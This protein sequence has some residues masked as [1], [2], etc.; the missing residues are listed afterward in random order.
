MSMRKSLFIILLLFIQLSC[1]DEKQQAEK[2]LKHYIDVKVDLI[3]NYTME[4]SVALWNATV[5]GSETDYQKF[6]D[7][8]LD[9]NKSN[10]KTPDYFSPDRFSSFS[11]NVFTNE[12]DFQLLRKLKFSG[13]ITDT[14]LNRQLNVL[15]HTF[16]GSQI[17]TEKYKNLVMSEMNLW[18]EFSELKVMIRG[19]KYGTRQ[20]D[21]IRKKTN[22]APL[23]NDIS[24]AIKQKGQSI[25]PDIVRMVKDRNGFATHF[26]YPDFY[27]MSLETKDQTPKNIKLLL[28]EI[29]LKTR[30]EYFEA[31]S[32]IDKLLAKRFN[33][34]FSDLQPWNYNNELSSFLPQKFISKMD[35]L[36]LDNDPIQKTALFCEEI[37]LPIQDVID[38]S[39]LKVG[40]GKSGLTAMI[41]VDFRNDIR[42][43]AGIENSFDGMFR[44]MHL[45]G[46]AAHYK[47]ISDDIPYLLKT[48]NSIV[49]EGIAHYFGNLASDYHWLKNEVKL[50]ESKQNEF[51]MVC[52]HM[53]Q[54]DRLF[55]CRKLLVNAEFEREMYQNP[56]QDLD[57]LWFDLNLRYLG[58]RYPDEK[59][60]CY[61]ATNKFNVSLGCIVHNLVLADVF[62]AQLQHSVEVRVLKETNG[63]YTNNKAVGTYLIGNLFYYG[64]LLPWDQ[65]IEKATGE[66]LNSIYLVNQLVG[67]NR[68]MNKS[69]KK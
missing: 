30:N 47:N 53:Q 40:P 55:R 11:Q 13:L 9:F 45:G 69:M 42:L 20:L 63:V 58:F 67:N 8:D 28:A 62:A 48:P 3:R 66:P 2:I 52:Q 61:W 34:P 37:G 32:I 25:A 44:M 68:T 36:F 10:K 56:D 51:V 64:N 4:S 22:D 27:Q 35:S 39:D 19:K 46:H 17:E 18:Q 38:N 6:V 7:I 43:I 1:L 50:D 65:L 14:L 33:I 23:L 29:E 59:N 21:S 57:S 31:K 41:N 49:G 5:S 60:A 24:D 54:V 15:Y 26:G 16:M 12:Q